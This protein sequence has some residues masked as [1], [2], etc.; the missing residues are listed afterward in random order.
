MSN[1]NLA[2]VKAAKGKKMLLLLA[3]VFVLP[4]TIAFTLHLLD[5][6]PGGKSFGN[7]VTPVV[8]LKMPAFEDA[9]GAEFASEKWSEIW[10]IVTVE[11][12]AC[13]IACESN[14]DKLDRVRRSMHKDTDRLQQ[15]LM[16]TEDYDVQAIEA[17]QTKFPYLN[18]LPAKT[19][20]QKQFVEQFKQ[21]ATAGSFYLVDP[22]NNL[23]MF[24]PQDVEPKELR[25]D[26]KRLFKNS[27]G[28]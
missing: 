19:S 16:L 14:I 9:K 23:M 24:Y 1:H 26:I 3:L 25:A 28:G 5:I 20:S 18:I 27:W 8:E 2:D 21:V 22:L 12:G 15:I 7:L 17:L 4:F 6:R 11:A 13:D 10:S